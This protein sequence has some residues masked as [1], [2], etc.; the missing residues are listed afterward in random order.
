MNNETAENEKLENYHENSFRFNAKAGM[1][2]ILKE[3]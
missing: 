2:E 1:K 3:N